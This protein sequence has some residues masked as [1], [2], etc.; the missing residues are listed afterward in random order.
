MERFLP[1]E[2]RPAMERGMRGGPAA[3]DEVDDS[4]R[5]GEVWVPADAI[6]T[7]SLSGEVGSSLPPAHVGSSN[8]TYIHFFFFLECAAVN[9]Y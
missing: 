9:M 4:G 7:A 5:H 3:A 6:L 1:G 8:A 2:N